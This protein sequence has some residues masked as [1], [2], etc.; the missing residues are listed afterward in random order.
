MPDHRS[1]M[2][3]VQCTSDPVVQMT[4]S[5]VRSLRAK[6]RTESGNGKGYW[7]EHSLI[8]GQV[9]YYEP[10]V[11]GVGGPRI[12]LRPIATLSGEF[13]AA[14]APVISVAWNYAMREEND[15]RKPRDRDK[16]LLV[17]QKSGSD[18]GWNSPEARAANMPGNHECMTLVTGFSD[19]DVMTV[20][21]TVQNLR[22]AEAPPKRADN[23]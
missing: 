2:A 10:G 14:T 11:R 8:V 23:K 15:V 21:Q 17:V 1:P 19:P 20:L 4:L 13:D 16:V 7:M 12:R 3:V 18:Q 5:A 9:E 22:R 6:P